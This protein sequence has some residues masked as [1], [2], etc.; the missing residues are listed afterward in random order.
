[1]GPGAPGEDEEG[2]ADVVVVV[3]AV[4]GVALLALELGV[5]LL[6][7]VMAASEGGTVAGGEGEGELESLCFAA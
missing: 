1:M 4:G 5:L 6:D 7:E 3:V 2:L